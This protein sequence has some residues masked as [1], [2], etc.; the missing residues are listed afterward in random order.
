MVK[1]LHGYIFPDVYSYSVC[2]QWIFIFYDR[3]L[4]LVSACV[5]ETPLECC[6]DTV[7]SVGPTPA[8]LFK[9][10]ARTAFV[11]PHF[12]GMG[13]FFFFVHIE[14]HR[15]GDTPVRKTTHCS[16]SCSFWL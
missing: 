2:R 13:F 1:D 16:D 10:R 9:P 5:F 4:F 14:H 8:D 6:F 11:V 15:D 7:R 12:K 3:F